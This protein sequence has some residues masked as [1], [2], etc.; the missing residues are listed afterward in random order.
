[1]DLDSY[2][3]DDPRDFTLLK[4]AT[5][6]EIK[7]GVASKSSWGNVRPGWH[8]QCATMARSLLGD[9]ADIHVGGIDL[10]FP[11]HENEIAICKAVTGK[12]PSNY[13]L[14]SG[15]VMVDG[16]KMSRS[17]DNA[18]SVRD[19]LARG[20]HGRQ[21]RLLLLSKHY[22]QPLHFSDAALQGCGAR[23]QRLDKCVLHLRSVSGGAAHPDL[24]LL[25]AEFDAAFREAL[26]DDLNMAAAIAALFHL[27]RR[28]NRR[29][30]QGEIGQPDAETLLAVLNRADTVL[31]VLPP[32]RP[33]VDNDEI[34]SLVRQREQ[35][36]QQRDFD[37]ADRL[38]D[39]IAAK[40]A[41]VQDTQN[42][43]R[44]RPGTGPMAPA[45]DD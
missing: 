13:W 32:E 28:V 40:G 20:Y 22:R 14:H 1:V 7:R 35:A 29:L 33:S 5:L 10:I 15:L 42:G 30:G 41:V 44:W 38:R 31:G 11:H 25:A 18:V 3:K 19:L 16:R 6:G 43:P 45:T 24:A 21:I 37:T 23:L 27:V 12:R 4:R 9:Q 34:D 36:R 8:I 2:E 39:E 26:F 17:N